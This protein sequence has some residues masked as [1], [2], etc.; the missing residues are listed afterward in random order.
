MKS[1]CE[2]ITP[3]LSPVPCPLSSLQEPRVC[4]PRLL[5]SGPAEVR[6]GCRLH[7]AGDRSALP[8]LHLERLFP[9]T[10]VRVHAPA[11]DHGRLPLLHHNGAES[12]G[13]VAVL[14]RPQGSSRTLSAVLCAPP[15]W[16]HCVNIHY[17]T[18][19][20]CLVCR[21]LYSS[22]Y[23]NILTLPNFFAE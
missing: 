5:L 7:R 11:A 17:R 6:A 23:L 9:Q 4:G 3:P 16:S 21:K 2:V 18:S 1:L 12:R 20:V 10:T 22:L 8:P 19:E 13:V 14:G 15:V